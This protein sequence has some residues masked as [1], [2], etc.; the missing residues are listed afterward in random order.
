VELHELHV[1]QLGP[2]VV[3]Q[4]VPVA[5]ALPAVG[6]DLVGAPE[7]ARRQHHRLGLEHLEDAAVARVGHA[8]GDPL[9]VLEQRHHRDL[10]VHVHPLVDAVVLER[11]D[12]LEP[13][14][15][16][17]VGQPRVAVPAE[18][19]LEDLPVL[20]AVEPRPPGLQLAHPVRRLARVQLGH[21]PVVDVLAAAHGVRE[22][23]LP[24]V[25]LVDV[26]HRR[27]HPALRH[28][29]V[30]LAQQR[31]ADEPHLH[32]RR[33]GLDGRAQPGAPRADHQDVVLVAVEV[34]HQMILQSW[35]TPAAQR[36]M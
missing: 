21:A 3:G 32:P 4:G 25:A 34:G 36:R 16:A 20:G 17:D 27:R 33:R 1:D 22:V 31:L 14:A 26:P 28:D 9:A 35:I 23:H 15:V 29:G 11:P 18:V 7:A 13:G 12:Q 2:S 30:G 8:P 19:A 6:G 5:G 24:V 10:H